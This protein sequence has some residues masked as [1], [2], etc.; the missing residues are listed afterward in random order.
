MR[1]WPVVAVTVASRSGCQ[2]SGIPCHKRFSGAE[3]GLDAPKHLAKEVW[4]NWQTPA[5]EEFQPRNRFSLQ[6]AYTSA[7][8]LLDPVPKFKATASLAT[9][10]GN[11]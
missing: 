11:N 5:H 6:N 2:K 4:T 1:S 10:F 8:H 7:F 3:D 9:S